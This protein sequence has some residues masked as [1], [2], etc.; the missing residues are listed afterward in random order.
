MQYP[1]DIADAMSGLAVTYRYWKKYDLAIEYYK[2][3]QEALS[4]APNAKDNFYAA[5]GLAITYAE[6]GSC[7]LAITA[8]ERALSL[9][10]FSHYD[11]ELYK[12]KASCL[13]TLQR[14]DEAED[15]LFHAASE[16]AKLPGLMGTS[17]QLEVIKISGELTHARGKYDLGY[18]MLKQ[19]YEQYAELLVKKTSKELEKVKKGLEYERLK[20]IKSLEKKRVEV[21]LLELEKQKTIIAQE[22]YLKILIACLVLIVFVVV[23]LQVKNNKKIKKL[24]IKDC[25]LYTSPSPRD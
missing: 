1:V 21:E 25:L 4:Y 2:K 18:K 20:M 15:A 22:L 14:L 19:Y 9:K 17:W 8:I 10:G 13:I 23:L 16:F 24:T 7:E 6:K 11:A 3:Y 12:K 5:Y